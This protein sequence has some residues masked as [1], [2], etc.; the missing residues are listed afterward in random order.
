MDEKALTKLIGNLLDNKLNP[1]LKTLEDLKSK[2]DKIEQ[3]LNFLSGKYD[4]L[5]SNSS[6]VN[7]IIRDLNEE[8]K[9]IKESLHKSV[10]DIE[11]L[12]QEVNNMEQYMRRDCLEIR[13]IPVL[14]GEDTS[15]L[16]KKVGEII[17]VQVQDQ[18]ISISHR[19]TDSRPDRD[20][21]LIVKFARR[22]VRDKFYK[23]RK[24]LRGKSLRDIGITRFAGRK[25]FIV[26]SLT[27]HNR[28]LFNECLQ[29]KKDLNYRFIWTTH[30]KIL[31]R[32]DEDSPVI[33]ITKRNDIDKLTELADT[34][35]RR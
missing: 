21:A 1:V 13:G 14:T 8:N 29:K 17:E 10:N 16:V 27:Q 33:T 11:L 22:N 26:E 24:N 6:N 31:L 32:K 7:N 3:S 20:P 12:K 30:G 2:I 19:L 15:Q 5:I 28:K 25:I 23:V 4:E 18:D 9:I 35:T 34:G